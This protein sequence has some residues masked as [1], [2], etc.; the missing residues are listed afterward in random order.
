MMPTGLRRW[1]GVAVVLAV[2][3]GGTVL[4]VLAMAGVSRVQQQHASL[5]MDHNADAIQRAVAN[6]AARYTDTLTDMAQAVG[7]QTQFNAADFE[8]ITARLT[9]S[10]LPG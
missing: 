4:S 7:S 9:R 6:E 2:L 3:V 1:I 10:R 8:A 5:L